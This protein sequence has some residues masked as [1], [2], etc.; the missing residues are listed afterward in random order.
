[1][2]KRHINL[3]VLGPGNI[4]HTVI[5]AIK[6]VEGINKYAVASRTMEKAEA[7]KN[8]FNFTKAYG[9][10]EE[11]LQ[12]DKVDLVYIAT[13]HAFHYEQMLMCIKYKKNI[14]CEKAF[15]LNANHAK[16]ILDLAKENNI[17]ITEALL[18]GFLPS[19]AVI[20]ELLESSIIGEVKS[21]Y[22]VFGNELMHV[23]RVINKDLGGGALFDIGIYPLY[24]CLSTFGWNPTIIDKQIEMYNDVDKHLIVKFKYPN[25]IEATVETSI[26]ENLGIFGEI[27]GTKGKIIIQNIARPDK[28]EVYDNNGK[29]IKK[30]EDLRSTTGYEYEFIEARDTILEGKI[31]TKAMPHKDTIRL[32]ECID[33]ILEQ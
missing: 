21:F 7:F 22:G 25:N 31:E 24:F 26:S 18:T 28:I 16:H 5:K 12:D 33:M 30:I 10:Y 17:F 3:G 9:S 23:E 27:T 29:L 1:M 6:D 32:L 2:N 11:L 14:I 15:C 20:N 19:R 8:E 13:P 4:A